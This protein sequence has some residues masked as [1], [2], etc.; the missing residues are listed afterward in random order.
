MTTDIYLSEAEQNTFNSFSD[1]LKEGWNIISESLTCYESERQIV[2]RHRMADFTAFPQVAAMLDRIVEGEPL[3]HFSLS[4]IPDEV[5][6]EIYFTMGARGVN[7]FIQTLLPAI[8]T[9]DDVVALATLSAARHKLLEIN[10][11]ATHS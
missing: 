1:S 4:T 10:S 6:K 11:S 2:M 5:Q 8:K 3:E 9:D 7:A